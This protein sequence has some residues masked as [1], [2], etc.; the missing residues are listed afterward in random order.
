MPCSAL[1]HNVTN[2]QAA[3]RSLAPATWVN[4]NAAWACW[5]LFLLSVN[6]HPFAYGE[7]LILYFLDFLMSSAYSYSH[8]SKVLAGI[9]FF[10]KWRNLPSCSRF[11]FGPTGSIR[12][13][14][15]YFFY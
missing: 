12:I 5:C 2:V 14:Q 13:S 9:S 7:Q 8:I 15:M 4:Y 6:Q 3:V 11:F 1:V 10:V